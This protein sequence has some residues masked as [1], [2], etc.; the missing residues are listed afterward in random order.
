MIK[1]RK[2]ISI[3][4]RIIVLLFVFTSLGLAQGVSGEKSPE[5]YYD[6]DRGVDMV[7]ITA[8]AE[9][10]PIA[11]TKA[12]GKLYANDELYTIN[13]K[14]TEAQ[15]LGP[16][17]VS[18]MVK[19]TANDDSSGER[20]KTVVT[21]IGY[22]NSDGELSLRLF[23]E[24][25]NNVSRQHYE[26][27]YDG[28]IFSALVEE[29]QSLGIEIRQQSTLSKS[30]IRLLIPSDLMPADDDLYRKFKE[31]EAFEELKKKVQDTNKEGGN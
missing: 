30:F 31:S 4:I 22:A 26:M 7:L 1:T 23:E 15:S 21:E 3:S 13:G 14:V 17:E 11:L 12:V 25:V 5:W 27:I 2:G 16:I 9:S 20:K 24:I 10:F 29:M 18:R 8:T 6:T 19:D 28:M